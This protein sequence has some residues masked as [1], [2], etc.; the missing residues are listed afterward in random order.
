MSSADAERYSLRDGDMVEVVSRRG[1][2]R[3]V[4]R[5]G[6][7]LDGHVFVPFH[8]G[9]WDD[10]SR[11]RA[12]NELTLTGWDPVSKQP[13]FKFAAVRIARVTE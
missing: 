11:S 12:A 4:A 13:Y 9:S 2:I 1:R 10:A 6:G 8:Y 3:A 7:I 5:V